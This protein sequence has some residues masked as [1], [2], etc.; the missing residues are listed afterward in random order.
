MYDT[1]TAFDGIVNSVT[2]ELLKQTRLRSK[3]H[4]V[5]AMMLLVLFKQQQWGNDDKRSNIQKP[6]SSW[7]SWQRNA[8]STIIKSWMLVFFHIFFKD[9]C[10]LYCSYLSAVAAAS[11][12]ALS[13]RFCRDCWKNNS[14][15][16]ITD[17]IGTNQKQT[18][19]TTTTTMQSENNYKTTWT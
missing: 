9:N 12:I 15:H 3:N 2:D 16:D 1:R 4:S 18:T 6:Y 7:S 11:S 10:T 19:T 13:N 8:V 5:P 17:I 14:P